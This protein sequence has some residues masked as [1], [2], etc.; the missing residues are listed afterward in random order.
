VEVPGNLLHLLRWRSL[1]VAGL[2]R[3]IAQSDVL[4][5][6]CYA[7]RSGVCE[8]CLLDGLSHSEGTLHTRSSAKRP[9]KYEEGF[10]N[11]LLISSMPRSHQPFEE[12]NIL[13][14]LED[15]FFFSCRCQNVFF[16][17]NEI[18]NR[19]HRK[20]VVITQKHDLFEIP[21]IPG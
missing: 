15:L 12:R 8:A 13:L 5:P 3:V 6:R 7:A 10:T 9:K 21:K 11:R 18:P 17:G 16:S 19:E 2:L 1:R 14:C 20:T 4:T